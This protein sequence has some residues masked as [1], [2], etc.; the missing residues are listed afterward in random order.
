MPG[1]RIAFGAVP[2]ARRHPERPCARINH[3]LSV[4]AATTDTV[5]MLRSRPSTTTDTRKAGGSGSSAYQP[6]LR[7]LQR[8]AGNRAVGVLVQRDSGNSGSSSV[9]LAVLTTPLLAGDP[10]L[11]QAVRNAPPLRRGE[12]SEG[13]AR[14]QHGLV[15]VG[16]DMP[17]SAR[18]AGETDGIYGAETYATVRRFQGHHG[19]RPVGGHEAGRKTLTA[20]DAAIVGMGPVP[21]AF[22]QPGSAGV[23]SRPRRPGPIR[24]PSHGRP[25]PPTSRAHTAPRSPTAFLRST[26]TE[27][28]FRPDVGGGAQFF[29][30]YTPATGVL[31]IGVKSRADF[32][33]S[34]AIVRQAGRAHSGRRARR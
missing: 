21:A 1:V 28:V 8:S 20:L 32:R 22:G 2:S 25:L 14:L 6:A 11:Q 19:V 10:R 26:F 5:A 27:R 29:V 24:L 7:H 33:H 18:T 17:R 23:L 4:R 15:A 3:T 13:V 9:P 12:T 31:F 16:Y 34:A 30:R